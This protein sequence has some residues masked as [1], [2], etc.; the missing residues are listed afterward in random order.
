MYL[1]ELS[2]KDADFAIK[3]GCDPTA[4]YTYRY[5]LCRCQYINIDSVSV[6]SPKEIRKQ[7]CCDW[8]LG[9]AV[10]GK[11]MGTKIKIF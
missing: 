8:W 5:P 2:S 6:M 3:Y 11:E 7:A 9:R 1:A 10:Q 4:W